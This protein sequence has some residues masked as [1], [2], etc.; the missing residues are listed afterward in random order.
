MKNLKTFENFGEY[1][2]LV[3]YE[4]NPMLRGYIEC[5]L[6]AD[7]PEEHIG[8]F[9]SEDINQDSLI[10]AYK[11]VN[12]FSKKAY[13]YLKNMDKEMLNNVGMDFWYTRNGHG[14]GFFDRENY[15]GNKV[16]SKLEEIAKD[17]PSKTVFVENGEFFID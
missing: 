2:K 6:F 11:D 5:A 12:N 14:T 16:A 15:Y 17:F 8:E 4:K 7:L 3:D 13:R 9:G 10:D 1:D